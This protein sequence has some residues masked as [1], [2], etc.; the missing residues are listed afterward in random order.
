VTGL[1]KAPD[2]ARGP[3]G[4]KNV[5]HGLVERLSTDGEHFNDLA[6][7]VFDPALLAE[8]GLQHGPAACLTRVSALLA[9]SRHD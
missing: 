1:R 4:R 3:S 9:P 7:T 8:G 6:H 5:E 2:D